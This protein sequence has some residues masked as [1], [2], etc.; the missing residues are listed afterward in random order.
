M[1]ARS[2][3]STGHPIRSPIHMKEG[4]LSVAYDRAS[5]TGAARIGAVTLQIVRN[6]VMRFNVGYHDDFMIADGIASLVALGSAEGYGPGWR[7][8]IEPA[9]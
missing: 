8:T 1:S 3:P 7:M 4:P 2:S 9:T 6:L 5:R